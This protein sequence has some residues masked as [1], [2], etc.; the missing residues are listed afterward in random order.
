MNKRI[1]IICNSSS[2]LNDFRGMLIDK[3]ISLKFDVYAIVPPSDL[4]QEII[5]EEQLFERG[6]KL[7]KFPVDRHGINPVEDLKLFFSY[8]NNQKD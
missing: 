8:K 5:A 7:I 1:L 2:G 3:L 6:C 4:K